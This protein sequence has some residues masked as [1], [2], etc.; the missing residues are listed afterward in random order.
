MISKKSVYKFIIRALL[1]SITYFFI[2][3]FIFHA[4]DINSTLMGAI[5]GGFV[6][7]L[8]QLIVTKPVENK[9]T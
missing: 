1:F 9:I 5:V 4:T 3:T 2:R 7:F 6:G 8:F